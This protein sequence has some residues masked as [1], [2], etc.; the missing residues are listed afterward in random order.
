MS[1]SDEM[2]VLWLFN[3][4]YP[5]LLKFCC[6][7]MAKQILV[8]A[9]SLKNLY[10]YANQRGQIS[11]EKNI[12]VCIYGLYCSILLSYLLVLSSKNI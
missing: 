10:T 1:V 5:L 9:N 7:L 4:T 3:F 11:P 8:E 6:D 2:T 12:L